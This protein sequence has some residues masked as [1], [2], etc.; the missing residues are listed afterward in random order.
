MIASLT[1]IHTGL[2]KNPV[3]YRRERGLYI[4][5]MEI[6]CALQSGESVQGKITRGPSYIIS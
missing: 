6:Y 3:E 4:T 5:A 1:K 2:K